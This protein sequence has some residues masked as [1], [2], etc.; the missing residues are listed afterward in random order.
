[1]IRDTKFVEVIMFIKVVMQKENLVTVITTQQQNT[2]ITWIM[3]LHLKVVCMSENLV[4]KTNKIL[5]KPVTLW[6]NSLACVYAYVS[7]EMPIFT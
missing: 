7:C 5:E 3:N 1:M 2:E 4:K 6:I